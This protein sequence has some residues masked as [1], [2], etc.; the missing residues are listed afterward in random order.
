M[1][2][3]EMEGS[4]MIIHSICY[5]NLET[6]LKID[7]VQFKKGINLLVGASGTG[8]TQILRAIEKVCALA[9]NRRKPNLNEKAKIIFSI[10]DD[11]KMYTWEYETNK[12]VDDKI[13]TIG[14][15][16]SQY[17]FSREKLSTD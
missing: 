12:F 9:T 4:N 7:C 8:K 5:E 1:L 2:K 11:D 10:G 3:L 15:L 13:R 16:F 17:G 6:G 14:G